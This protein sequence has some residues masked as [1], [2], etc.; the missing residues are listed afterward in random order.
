MHFQQRRCMDL[1][2]MLRCPGGKNVRGK[3]RPSDN[4]MIVPIADLEALKEIARDIPSVTGEIA[5]HFWP[6]P[7]TMIFDKT[8]KVP[9]GTTGGLDTVAVRM[10]DDPIAKALII[11][12]GG[13]VGP[14]CEYIR[15][16]KSD[17]CRTC[18]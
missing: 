17:N 2:P 1:E 14:K 12:A 3:G 16:T 18:L 13:Y 15:A 9:Y 4:P 6:G 10:P 11:A 7:L 8:D 5:S